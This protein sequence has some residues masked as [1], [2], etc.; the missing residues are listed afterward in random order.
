MGR[1][2][3]GAARCDKARGPRGRPRP[4]V[5]QRVS[6]ERNTVVHM[7]HDPD[8]PSK[9]TTHA[10]NVCH[11][12]DIPSKRTTPAVQRCENGPS[13]AVEEAVEEDDARTVFVSLGARRRICRRRG[14]RPQSDAAKTIENGLRIS[15]V[16][17]LRRQPRR[18]ARLRHGARPVLRLGAHRGL[19]RRRRGV[20]ARRRR[21]VPAAARTA[22]RGDAAATTWIFRADE[23]QHRRGCKLNSPSVETSRSTAAVASWIVRPWRRVAAARS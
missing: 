17:D 9:R 11:D 13:A 22:S 18:Q 23:S 12:P 2:R 16:G 5:R 15:Q 8:M 19:G 10:R 3:L 4:H 14:R 1:R 7:C 20:R 21:R 6:A